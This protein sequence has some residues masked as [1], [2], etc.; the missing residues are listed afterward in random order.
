[1]S[2]SKTTKEF[3]KQVP[4]SSK[5]SLDFSQGEYINAVTKFM[6]ICPKHGEKWILPN[7]LK[8]GQGCDE[9][10]A[11]KISKSLRKPIDKVLD[12]IKEVYGDRYKTVSCEYK[13]QKSKLVFYCHSHGEFTKTLN[14]I[15]RGQVCPKCSQEAVSE[16]KRKPLE[17]ALQEFKEVHGD[18]YLY[19]HFTYSGAN[20]PSTVTCPTHGNWKVSASNHA[21][22]SSGC[23]T[24]W[25]E[26]GSSREEN[27]VAEFISS[28]GLEVKRSVPVLDGKH[29]DI[30]IPNLNIGIEYNG[31]YW[32]S[33]KGFTKA[34][35]L[36][37]LLCAEKKGIRLIHI[38]SDE[39]NTKKDIVKSR[40]RNILGVHE[41][42]VFA[43]KCSIVNLAFKQAS[44]FLEETHIQGSGGS[45][46]I[47]LGLE[48]EGSIIAVMTFG[49]PRF[50]KIENTYELVR[51]SSKG[52]VIGGFSKLLKSFVKNY[53]PGRIISYADRR[54]S[55]GEVYIRNG[56]S[57]SSI[58]L[59]GYFWS[60]GSKRL[61]RLHFQKHK[62]KDL[63]PIFSEEKSETENCIANGFFKVY[64]CG[65]LKFELMF[66]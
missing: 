37:K 35:L 6:V 11:D 32:H 42:S 31:L 41:S 13:N 34:S 63:L 36:D 5:E 61:N 57:Q 64:D 47:N 30:F 28:L 43:R 25:F 20:T 55:V 24:C 53:N 33:E 18:K 1:M 2:K 19:E 49:K 8:I 39:W 26:N 52:R 16:S 4:K 50:E 44:V 54:W 12:Q 27:E 21:G 62:L 17:V 46:S 56:F 51:F 66:Q 38:F 45:T 15:L 3:L 14:E 7:K 29:I 10:K 65:Q 58:S 23:P 9:C 60:K 48:L 40:L 59:P 22:K